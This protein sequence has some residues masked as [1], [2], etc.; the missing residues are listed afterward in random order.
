M[1]LGYTNFISKADLHM[2]AP[3]C[4]SPVEELLKKNVKNY[5]VSGLFVAGKSP[6]E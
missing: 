1:S 3:N 6:W 5:L 2:K 4:F